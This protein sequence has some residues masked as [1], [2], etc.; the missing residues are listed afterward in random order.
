MC[1]AIRHGKNQ[2]RPVQSRWGIPANE[3]GRRVTRNEATRQ[4]GPQMRSGGFPSILLRVWT[5]ERF[6]HNG[7]TP[8]A[9][10]DEYM[11]LNLPEAGRCIQTSRGRRAVLCPTVA[12][13]P[14]LARQRLRRTLPP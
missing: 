6:S 11:G 12:C 3:K 13:G 5:G 14:P 10:P 9:M 7:L 1:L 8:K 4:P 2:R